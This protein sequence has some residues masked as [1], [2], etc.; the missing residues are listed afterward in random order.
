MQLLY[1]RLLWLVAFAFTYSSSFAQVF[2]GQTNVI[3]PPGAPSVTV[4]ISESD[5]VV[6]GVGPLTGCLR[7]ERVLVNMTHTWTGDIGLFLISPAGTVL[8]LSTRNGGSQNDYLNT[9]FRDDAAIFITDGNP[10]F[11]GTFRPEGRQQDINNPNNFDPLGTFTLANT[12]AGENADGTW[13]FL[14]ND[15][16]S[17]DVGEILNWEIEF[18]GDPNG[19]I[20]VDLG[21]DLSVCGSDPTILS[22]TLN[23]ADPGATYSWST[24]ESTPSI[25]V[26]PS[27]PTTYEVTVTSG[28]CTATDEITVSPGSGNPVTITSPDQTICAGES[29]TLT[30]SGG[31]GGATYTWSTGQTG[32]SITVS[33]TA[34]EVFSVTLDEGGC[35]TTDDILIQVQENLTASFEPVSGTD[36]C[37]GDA[38]PFVINFTGNS[39]GQTYTINVDNPDGDD[40]NLPNVGISDGGFIGFSLV[41]NQTT[42]LT[43]T[44]TPEGSA[45]PITVV[46]NQVTITIGGPVVNISGP[47]SVCPGDN[48]TLTASGADS[49]SW[50]TGE[51][52]ASITDLALVTTT[53]TVTGTTGGCSSTE[54]VT[55][56][57]LPPNPT[58]SS[59]PQQ[60]CEGQS[61]TLSVTDVDPSATFQWS[62]GQFGS[63]IS[64]S[65]T[66]TTTYQVTVTE[67]PC[68]VIGF[69]SVLVDPAGTADLSI[70]GPDEVCAGETVELLVD[71]DGGTNFGPF[72]LIIQNPNGPDFTI[73]NFN[74]TG[75]PDFTTSFTVN[76][77]TTFTLVI[78]PGT[79]CPVTV[80]Q[81]SVTVTVNDAPDVQI[82][83]DTEICP[84]ENVTLVATGA[85]TYQWSSG[86]TGETIFFFMPFDGQ[87]I[88]VTGTANGC[89]G[90]DQAVITVVPLNAEIV[91]DQPSICEGGSITLTGSGGGPG[92]SYDWSNGQTGQQITL[93]PAASETVT[94]TVTDG[95]CSDTQ[96]FEV[97][98]NSPPL[99]SVN[100]DFSL[101]AGLPSTLTA[102]GGGFGADYQWSTSQSG[103]TIN[104]FPLTTT[105]YTVTVTENGCT[106][107]DEVTVTVEEPPVLEL[108]NNQEICLGDNT[109]LFNLANGTGS[110]QWST[111]SA[112]PAINVN[113]TQSEL[114]GVT[115]TDG[116]CSSE[117][118]VLVIVTDVSVDLGP[119]VSICPGE[120]VVLT[121]N[122]PGTFLWSTNETSSSIVVS[123]GQTET[124]TVT[125]TLNGCTAS[126]DIEVVVL[127]APAVS[128][129]ADETI[130]AGESITLSASGTGPF[131]W[132]TNE[133]ADQIT[134][135]PIVTTTYTVTAGGSTCQASDQLTVFVAPGPSVELG[136]NQ[137]ICAGEELTLSTNVAGDTYSWSTGSNQP[138]ITISPTQA[139]VYTLSV[140]ENGCTAADSVEVTIVELEVEAGTDP[141]ICPG[142]SVVLM[143]TGANT[144]NWT[145]GPNSAD[146]VVN[147]T[148][149]TT[150]LVTGTTSGCTDQDSVTVNVVLNTSVSIAPQDAICPGDSVLL[151]ASGTGPFSWSTGEVGDE[152]WVQPA[153]STTFIAEAGVGACRVVDS[154]ELEVQPPILFDIGPDTTLCPGQDLTLELAIANAQ[155]EWSNGSTSGSANYAPLSP[156]TATVVV[157][158]DGCTATDSLS[159]DINDP[160]LSVSSDTTIC[161]G[162]EVSLV[163][164]GTDAYLWSTTAT[165]ASIL[166]NPTT[167]TTYTIQGTTENCSVTEEVTVNV[168]IPG[169]V[170][171]GEDVTICPGDEVTLAASGSGPFTWSTNEVGSEISVSPTGSQTYVAT[172]GIGNCLQADTL[173]VFVL[174][175]VAASLGPDTTICAGESLVLTAQGTP[176]DYLWST[177][178]NTESI[179]VS[180][181]DTTTYS[182]VTTANGCTDTAEIVVSINAPAIELSADTTVC[183]GD[184]VLLIASGTDAYLWSTTA[185]TA[186]ILVNPTT[187]TTY[188][189]QGT[190]ENCSVTEEVTVNVSIPG[191]VTLGEDVTICPGDEVTLAASGSGPFSWSTN[192]T[193]DEITVNPAM[194]Q[195]YVA[196]TGIG[197]CLQADT[198]EV[199][200]LPQVAASLGPDTTICA[201][202]SLVLTAQGTPGDYLWSTNENTE[203]I[204]VSPA[205]TT[206]YSLV[207][208][209]NGC[210]DTAEVVVSVNTPVVEVSDDVITCPGDEVQLSA[211]GT[212]SFSWSTGAETADILVNPTTTEVFTVTGTTEAC[213]VQANVQV[214]VL[215]LAN[216]SLDANQS[217]CLGETVS[218]T[219]TSDA[220]LVWSTG[221]EEATIIV[222][223]TSTTIYGV[224]AGEG[225]CAVTD[226][227]VVEVRPLPVVNI[228]GDASAC[229]GTTVSLQAGGS[230]GATYSW[231]IGESTTAIDF[232]LTENTEI[233]LVADLD[234]CLD[235]TN[236]A[237]TAL[238]LP[239]VLNASPICADDNATY[240][241]NIELGGGTSPYFSDGVELIGNVLNSPSINSGDSLLFSFTDANGCA[242]SF[243]LSNECGCLVLPLSSPAPRCTDDEDVLELNALLPMGTPTGTWTVVG[244]PD[245]LSL[246]GDELI[247]NGAQAGTYRIQFEPEG[248]T[249]ACFSEYQVNLVLSDP[250]SAG[251]QAAPLIVCKDV[252]ETIDLAS[253]LVGFT[254]GGSWI[255]VSENAQG[256]PAFDQSSGRFNISGQV[257]GSYIFRYTTASIGPC[258]VTETEVVINIQEVLVEAEANDATCLSDCSGAISIV[259][260]NPLLLYG[261]D[262]SALSA[263]TQF[264][265]LCPGRYRIVAEDP[266]GCQSAIELLVD[267]PVLP[268]LEVG[269]DRELLL[270]DSIRLQVQTNAVDGLISWSPDVV[271]LDSTCQEVIVRPLATTLYVLELIDASGCTAS[272]DIQIL[273]DRNRTTFAPTA[274]SPNGD[275]TNDRFTVYGDAGVVSVSDLGIY[276]RWGNQVFFLSELPLNDESVGWDGRANGRVLNPAVFVYQYRI[277]WIDG[278]EEIVTG[279]V[280]LV[281]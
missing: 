184:E 77:T 253:E 279:E 229:V 58:V 232:T 50:S 65:P 241:W 194:S 280:T 175:Q 203:S 49:Y 104:I 17:L 13:T 157:T 274:F 193:G 74:G 240:Q 176:G 152:I 37:S 18:S 136:P 195:T 196:T 32:A 271:C 215:P 179:S 210:T 59:S 31:G 87:S 186:S 5:A 269:T 211:S 23:P 170:T 42:T 85:D 64:V 197:N 54:T 222:S 198:L 228:S 248:T 181:A 249:A 43:L 73:D 16:V 109:N 247:T 216:L 29:V 233:G 100:D 63:S 30:A 98:V 101:C 24:G 81:A 108:G 140:T 263:A 147:P 281:R 57:V 219:A 94:L 97:I 266:D 192:E 188:T 236:I 202:E 231:S 55:V 4:G 56:T 223:P 189:I 141:T 257:S 14:V 110:Y 167:T 148:Q 3:V 163:A 103:S 213:S 116:N 239:E 80:G 164:S 89:E 156:E 245:N 243:E 162:D 254:P 246:S 70:V 275:G 150:Y 267:E 114:Y 177:N 129:G 113:P 131:T 60:I 154:I 171:L 76:E 218:L 273:V 22:A 2:Q 272:D 84:G 165:T 1:S 204:S 45:C 161:P 72:D 201:G 67:G 69:I 125:R 52:T 90:Q 173:E 133:T 139:E 153:T 244:G 137:Q 134:V 122:G 82:T 107:T 276:D 128:L 115:L 144:Y 252:N 214:E 205:D 221:E 34:D 199:F 61:S 160:V 149:T 126:D 41:I 86:Q 10:P 207:T 68:S 158:V 28:G 48:F 117:D 88:S 237:L 8:E 62:T 143:A 124:F 155:Y 15:Y 7:V 265:S 121:A 200:V 9:E 159:I 185:T 238:E 102:T 251:I 255:A 120:S 206:T 220:S 39:G 182:L 36:F 235:S 25:S 47:N 130:C 33:P 95:D 6:T 19:N 142:E 21:P 258:P 40:F 250:V 278:R 225:N 105:T 174:P 53:Y 132:S 26:N 209:A 78:V 256:N 79:G 242:T 212:A 20:D 168:S 234:G 83:G 230:A 190:S 118:Q 127:A 268:V 46:P 166:V 51:S 270:G 260:P 99:V 224:V 92:A 172:T 217:I 226:S 12:F 119:D 38:V 35:T 71:F 112:A 277:N 169:S 138:S 91:A 146:F 111:G 27:T 135:S 93:T 208:T 11:T 151:I 264:N 227:I 191:S 75:N 178:E 44:V 261:L 187:T 183:P 262:E 106:N 259:N 123:P 145:D 66:T 180:P 96:D